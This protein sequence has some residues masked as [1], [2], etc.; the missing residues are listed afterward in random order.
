M[1]YNFTLLDLHI[2]LLPVSIGLR[3]SEEL[4]IICLLYHQSLRPLK[5][6]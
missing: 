1:I 5:G 4:G 3:V 6:T 2:F